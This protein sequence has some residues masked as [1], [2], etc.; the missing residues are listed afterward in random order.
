[1]RRFRQAFE[2]VAVFGV[3]PLSH[4]ELNTQ[5]SYMALRWIHSGLDVGGQV[6]TLYESL[7]VCV[8]VCLHKGW[9]V[10]RVNA[11]SMR[12]GTQSKT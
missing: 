1:M 11:S 12:H 2:E 4:N 8:S 5:A 9:W 6:A 10:E 3:G 7:C